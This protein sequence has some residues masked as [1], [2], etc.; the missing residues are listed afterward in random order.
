MGPSVLLYLVLALHAGFCMI[1]TVP[2]DP[3]SAYV[4]CLL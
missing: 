2:Y 4:A 3:L 1:T